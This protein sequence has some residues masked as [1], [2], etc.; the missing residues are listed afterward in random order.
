[1]LHAELL[2]RNIL[3]GRRVYLIRYIPK[4]D[5]GEPFDWA[6]TLIQP[7]HCSSTVTIKGLSGEAFTR[8]GWK[9]INDLLLDMGFKR[10]K[11]Q[12]R[13]KWRCYPVVG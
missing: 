3:T 4:R 12:R 8:S 7:H 13:G 11:A 5:F 10:A 2:S 1:M 9:A 6:F